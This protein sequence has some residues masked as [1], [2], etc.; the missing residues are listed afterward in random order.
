LEARSS[1]N[2][3]WKLSLNVSQTLREAGLNA[4]VATNGEEG[5]SYGGSYVGGT[6]NR[7]PVQVRDGVSSRDGKLDFNVIG[8][9]EIEVQMSVMQEPEVG[10]NFR[11]NLGLRHRVRHV[12]FTDLTWVCY[13]TPSK[14]PRAHVAQPIQDPSGDD[15]QDPSGETITL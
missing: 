6:V 5:L 4:L 10:G 13:C 12:V 1:D 14:V 7:T 2:Y 11:D 9:T 15:I 8:L 3:F